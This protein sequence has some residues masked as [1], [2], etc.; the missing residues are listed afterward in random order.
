MQYPRLD[1]GAIRQV[2]LI[3]FHDFA[4]YRAKNVSAHW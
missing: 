1:S 2:V 4:I 3:V